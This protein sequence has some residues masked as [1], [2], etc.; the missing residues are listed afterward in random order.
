M[1]SFEIFL[2]VFFGMRNRIFQRRRRSRYGR[3]PQRSLA[4]ILVLTCVVGFILWIVFKS[5]V[6]LFSGGPSESISAELQILDGKAEFS[7]A[8][9]ENWTPAYSEQKF[10][11]EDS[12]RT[13][14]N[15]KV[16]LEITGGNTVFLGE[17]S[18]LEFL[19]LEQRSSSRKNILLRLKKGR[20]W[21]KVSEN[22]FG[23]ESKSRFEVE[24]DRLT[25]YVRG[26][27]FAISSGQNQDTVRLVRGNIEVDVK[28]DEEETKNVKMGVGQKLV[29]S[30]ETIKSI[31]NNQDILEIIDSEFIESEWH[32]QNLE[33]FYPQE[34]AQI[35][36]RIELSVTIKDKIDEVPINNGLE[37]P[38]ILEPAN[39]ERISAGVDAVKIEGTAPAQAAQIVVNGFTLTKFQPGDRKWTYFAAKRF[40][41]LVP[42]ENNFSVYAVTRDGKKSDTTEVTIFYEG[43]DTPS[44]SAPS[45]PVVPSSSSAPVVP[46]STKKPAISDFLPPAITSPAIIANG[47]TYETSADVVTIKGTV[48]PKTNTVKVNGYQLKKFKV[49]DKEFTYIASSR[50]GTRSNLKEGENVYEIMAFG[51]DGKTATTMVKVIYTPVSFGE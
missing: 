10:F 2:K 23:G 17:N 44:P 14:A 20:I 13:G 50:Y 31:A 45:E 51:P 46:I 49:G 7:L 19:E 26:T 16:A 9:N 35:R 39:E 42:G 43:N 41:T 24:T 5:V 48:D 40:G 15:T 29:V 11:S 12:L 21:A 3:A 22:D 27:I 34:A 28:V 30:N 4:R 1:P 38:E 8:E 47:E 6:G 33:K 18:E 36:R 37:A 32:I 25:T